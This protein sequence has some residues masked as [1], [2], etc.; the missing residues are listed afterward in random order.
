MK[1]KIDLS[2]LGEISHF[3]GIHVAK[4]SDGFYSFDQELYNRKIANHHR[5]E[6]AKGSKI[7]L[8]VDYYRSPRRESFAAAR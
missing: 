5:L 2:S 6:K 7:P 4:D 3:L 8:D 1:T